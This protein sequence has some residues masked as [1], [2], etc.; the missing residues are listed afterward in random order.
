MKTATT[1]SLSATVLATLLQFGAAAAILGSGNNVNVGAALPAQTGEL[2]GHADRATN[3]E[4]GV[5]HE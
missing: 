5:H 2:V 4:I 3:A 1:F